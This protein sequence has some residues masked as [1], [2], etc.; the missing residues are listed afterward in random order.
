MEIEAAL[1]RFLTG[2]PAKLETATGNPRLNAVVI[3]ADD[4]TGLATR[5]ERLNYGAADLER[6]AASSNLQSAI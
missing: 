4:H 3:E 2:M 6:L 5:I 1:G